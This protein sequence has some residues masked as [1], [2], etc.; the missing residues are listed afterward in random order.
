MY[1]EI[2]NITSTFLN[3][4]YTFRYRYSFRCHMNSFTKKKYY[5]TKKTSNAK[6]NE[7]PENGPLDLALYLS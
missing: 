7:S 1:T 6:G 3:T 4:S 5:V 2:L